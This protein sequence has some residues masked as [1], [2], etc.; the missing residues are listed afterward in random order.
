[1]VEASPG[2]ISEPP[3]L[4]GSAPDTSGDQMCR[5]WVPKA[6]VAFLESTDFGERDPRGAIWLHRMPIRWLPSRGDRRGVLWGRA[7]GDR[8]GTAEVPGPQI[9][10]DADGFWIEIYGGK[11]KPEALIFILAADGKGQTRSIQPLPGWQPGRSRIRCSPA[12]SFRARGWD[13]IAFAS[14]KKNSRFQQLC[15]RGA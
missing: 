6:I 9:I 5:T 13:R 12:P 2:M 7:G 4:A 11:R 15:R 3:Q 10:E 8:A 14:L 1:M